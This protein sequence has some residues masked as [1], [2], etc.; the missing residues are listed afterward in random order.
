VFLIDGQLT[1]N[2]QLLERRDGFGLWETESVCF[3]TK[4]ASKL[5]IIEVPMIV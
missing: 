4:T 5:L 2:D 1:A 3:E